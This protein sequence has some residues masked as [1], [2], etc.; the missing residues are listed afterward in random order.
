M[1]DLSFLVSP[2]APSPLHHPYSS[3]SRPSTRSNSYTMT[4]ISVRH[5]LQDRIEAFYNARAPGYD[6]EPHGFH[7]RLADD[8]VTF[9][10]PHIPPALAS[11]VKMLD[12]CCGTGMVSLAASELYGLKTIVHGV[13]ISATSLEIARLKAENKGLMN[14]EFFQSSATDFEHLGLEKGTYS[15][16]TCCS[17]LVLLGGDLS[18]VVGSWAEYL[19]P[20]GVLIVD[21]PAANT[22][23]VNNAASQAT[24]VLNPKLPVINR[25][26]IQSKDSLAEVIGKSGRLRTVR[27][28]ES[29]VYKTVELR[30]EDVEVMW[31]RTATNPISNL[32][33]LTDE[34]RGCIEDKFKS[35]LGEKVDEDGVLRD[36]YRLYLGLAVNR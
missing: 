28:W 29:K 2:L 33:G 11:P 3:L 1:R 36:H 6:T 12:L 10:Q 9:A 18:A 26:W 22:Q 27:V 19:R 8:F 31:E 16:V 17:A 32:D 5:P 20:G 23:V 15:L 25:D 14:A 4:G 21:V 35:T 34:E 24:A 7:Q 13:D 30:K